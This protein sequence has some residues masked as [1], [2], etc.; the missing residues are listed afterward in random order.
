[1]RPDS[2]TGSQARSTN[3][4][5]DRCIAVTARL[6]THDGGCCV[7]SSALGNAPLVQANNRFHRSGDVRENAD[8]TFPGSEFPLRLAVVLP[9]PVCEAVPRGLASVACGNR[10]RT[11]MSEWPAIS[12]TRLL[13]CRND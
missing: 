6:P 2:A 5:R 9:N 8:R 12:L 7:R 11:A 4:N 3:A 1:M 13:G 10:M